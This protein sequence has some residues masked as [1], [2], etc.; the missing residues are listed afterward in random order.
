MEQI[1]VYEIP[2]K[3]I[4]DRWTWD[5]EKDLVRPDYQQPT[6]KKG[7]TEEGKNI[8][9]YTSILNDFKEEAKDA[10]TT[11][12]GMALVR[13]HVSAFRDDMDALQKRQLKKARKD[14]DEGKE[15]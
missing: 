15:A 12:E 7:M 6:V 3:Y 13:K 1:G 5:P 14:K 11:D 9:R 2:R 10:C 4:L 8:M